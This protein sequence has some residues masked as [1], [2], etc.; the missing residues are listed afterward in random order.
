MSHFKERL[1]PYLCG[2][3]KGF[4]T[5]Q[6]LLTLIENCKLSLDTQGFSGAVLMDLSKAFDTL[7]HELLIAKLAAYGFD[8]KSLLLMN[9]YLTNR[10]QRTKINTSFSSWTE[11]LFGVPQGSVLGPLLFNIYIND[12]FFELSQTRVCNYADDTTLFD[13]RKNM[14]YLI[15]NLEHDS[16]IAIT[17]FE[18]NYMKLN[19]EKCHFIISGHKYEHTYAKIG[20][21]KIWESDQVKLLGINIDRNL[22]FNIH[23]STLCAKAGRKLTVLN[24]LVKLLNLKKR[25]LSMKAFIESQFNYCPLIWMFHSRTLNSKINKLHERALRL[26]YNDETSSFEELLKRDNS[27]KIHTRNLHY[28]ATEVYKIKNSIASNIVQQILPMRDQPYQL[29]SKTCFKPFNPSTTIYGMNS[30]RYLGPEIWKLLPEKLKSVPSLSSFKTNI[31]DIT[32]DNCPCRLCKQYV[33]ELG[34][35]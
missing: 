29:R 33:K 5:Q 18:D 19:E 30:I 24:R 17:W 26:V 3:R 20:K 4:S 34:F 23:V 21:I 6:A 28:L 16:K 12:L 35:L 1:S 2:Y 25:R 27:V 15:K 14:N 7:D 9:S 8:K 31:K 13:C 11:L 22:K 32:F 10:W